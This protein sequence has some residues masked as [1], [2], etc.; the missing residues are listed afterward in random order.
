MT[1]RVR[2]VRFIKRKETDRLPSG[3]VTVNPLPQNDACPDAVEEESA[4]VE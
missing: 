4:S 1:S 2:G 3:L